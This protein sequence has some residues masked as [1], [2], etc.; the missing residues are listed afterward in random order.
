[1]NR[2]KIVCKLDSFLNDT[3]FEY[4]SKLYTWNDYSHKYNKVCDHRYYNFTNKQDIRD[5]NICDLV[6]VLL[7]L[8]KYFKLDLLIILI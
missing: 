2:L 4:S 3:F 6:S 7:F 5:Y 1:M 8:N